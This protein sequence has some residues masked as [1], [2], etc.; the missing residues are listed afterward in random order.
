MGALNETLKQLP[1]TEPYRRRYL[2]ASRD[3]GTRTSVNGRIVVLFV[4]VL[5]L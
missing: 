3:R 2:A 1:R 4:R 5:K